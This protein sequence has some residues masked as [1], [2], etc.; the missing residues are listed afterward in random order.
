MTKTRAQVL[1][2]HWESTLNLPAVSDDQM[3]VSSKEALFDKP[4]T[5]KTVCKL[6]PNFQMSIESARIERNLTT[7]QLAK[8]LDIPERDIIALEGG[9]VLPSHKSICALER[10]LNV[11]IT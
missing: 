7:A 11:T 1:E 4:S 6:M 5:S 10:Y 3:R 2:Q 8:T 9:D